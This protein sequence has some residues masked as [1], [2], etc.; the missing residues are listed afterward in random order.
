LKV[1][2]AAGRYR[3]RFLYPLVEHSWDREGYTLNL[4]PLFVASRKD[5]SVD[6]HFFPLFWQGR[7]ERRSAAGEWRTE[8]RH[9]YLLPLYGYEEKSH[10]RDYYFLFP[11]I[12]LRTAQ[13]S[14]QF[15]LW[16]AFFYRDEPGLGSVKLWPL[17]ADETGPTAGEFWVSRF[18]FLSKRFDSPDSWRYRLDPFLFR[19]SEGPDSFGIGG[20]F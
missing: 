20:L 11:L 18:L 16:P 8:Q 12:H 2:E 10:R 15:Q 3:L 14:F 9:F 19:V 13:E 1:E 6:N 17:H 7:T 4:T 5:R